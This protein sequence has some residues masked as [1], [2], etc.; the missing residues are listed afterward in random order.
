MLKK[1]KK[2]SNK[3]EKPVATAKPTVIHHPQTDLEKGDDCPEC[4]NGKL[5]KYAPANLLRIV[6]QSPFQS[7][8]HVMERLRCNTCGAYFTASLPEDVLN[9]GGA[10]PEVWIFSPFYHGYR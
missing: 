6:G 3:P 8:Q 5:Y 1:S 9:D 10:K 7:E 2:K 4:E